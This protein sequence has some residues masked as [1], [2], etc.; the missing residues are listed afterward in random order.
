MTIPTENTGSS[1]TANTG[2]DTALLFLFDALLLVLLPSLSLSLS[3][4]YSILNYLPFS[5]LKFTEKDQQMATLSPQI[6]PSVV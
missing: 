4:A 1:R 3:R 6:Y 5:T 2:V